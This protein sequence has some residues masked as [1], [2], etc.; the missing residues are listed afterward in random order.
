[1]YG[2]GILGLRA[3]DVILASFPKSGST[4]VRFFLCNLVSLRYWEGWRGRPRH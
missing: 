1:M 3:Q 2:A 4:W